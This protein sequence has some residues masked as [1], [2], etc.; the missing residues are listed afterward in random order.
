MPDVDNIGGSAWESNPASPGERGATDFEDREGHRTPFASRNNSIADRSIADRRVTSRRLWHVPV[1]NDAQDLLR[2][3]QVLQ[4]Q[5]GA[6][7]AQLRH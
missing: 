6:G 4:N 3:A 5:I 1:R 2:V 7:R